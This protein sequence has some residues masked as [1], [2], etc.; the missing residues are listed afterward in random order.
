MRGDLVLNI[1]ENAR[2]IENI[3]GPS[4]QSKILMFYRIVLPLCFPISFILHNIP[5]VYKIFSIAELHSPIA[6]STRITKVQT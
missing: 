5:I 1:P 6:F 2:S 4:T 3:S